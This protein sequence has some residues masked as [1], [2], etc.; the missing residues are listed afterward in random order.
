[1]TNE[2]PID[3][4]QLKLVSNNDPYDLEFLVSIYLRETEKE[5]TRLEAAVQS[6]NAQEVYRLAH[7]NA[8]TSQSYGMLAVV[9]PLKQLE[10]DA[11]A[12]NLSNAAALLAETE[13]Q[14]QRMQTFLLT[15]PASA[16]QSKAA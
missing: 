13:S 4:D 12:G 8:G 1:M 2:L 16:E 9:A 10:T 5:L 11:R 6:A 14:F 7:A 3:F 15:L